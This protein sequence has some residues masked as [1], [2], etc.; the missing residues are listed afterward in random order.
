MIDLIT[1]VLGWC[2]FATAWFVIVAGGVQ[3]LRALRAGDAKDIL[4]LSP[5]G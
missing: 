2:F 4:D 5:V 1:L 3:T